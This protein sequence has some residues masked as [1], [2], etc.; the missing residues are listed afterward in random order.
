M[1]MP[2]LTSL[3]PQACLIYLLAGLVEYLLQARASLGPLAGALARQ[4]QE[5]LSGIVAGSLA[6]DGRVV[7]VRDTPSRVGFTNTS[8]M[9][10]PPSG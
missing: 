4:C 2:R 10:L 7:R 1:S 5:K 6:I 8:V 3:K 9:M